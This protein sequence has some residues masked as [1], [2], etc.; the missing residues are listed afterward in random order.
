M[1]NKKHFIFLLGFTFHKSYLNQIFWL[2]SDFLSIFMKMFIP[3]NVNIAFKD[4]SAF[5]F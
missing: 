4:Q 2:T 1:P 3:N 5:L